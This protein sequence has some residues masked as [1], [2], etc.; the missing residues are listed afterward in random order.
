MYSINS[1]LK[2]TNLSKGSRS[3]GPLPVIS[4]VVV[5]RL[6]WNMESVIRQ[7]GDLTSFPSIITVRT[8]RGDIYSLVKQVPKPILYYPFLPGPI[9][10]DLISSLCNWPPQFRRE[11]FI[12][13]HGHPSEGSRFNLLVTQ[14]HKQ[15]RRNVFLRLMGFFP[16]KASMQISRGPRDKGQRSRASLSLKNLAMWSA[17]ANQRHRHY[18]VFY[19]AALIRKGGEQK[20]PDLKRL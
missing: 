4:K 18:S 3:L 11:Y 15:Q 6:A 10:A 17:I 7:L 16:F 13:G 19:S 20:A 9:G 12:C 14:I 2:S 8:S 1:C 5:A